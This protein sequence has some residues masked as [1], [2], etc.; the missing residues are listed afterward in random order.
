[1]VKRPRSAWFLVWLFG[2][3]FCYAI[4]FAL[5]LTLKLLNKMDLMFFCIFCTHGTA[6]ALLPG[7]GETRGNFGS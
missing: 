7:S 1:M 4:C 6:L 5:G 2:H 3:I